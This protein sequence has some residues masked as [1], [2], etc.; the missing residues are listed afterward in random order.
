MGGL[1]NGGME[2]DETEAWRRKPGNGSLDGSLETDVRGWKP[3]EME[4]R[5]EMRAR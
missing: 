1:G 2:T 5:T 4:R 3:G